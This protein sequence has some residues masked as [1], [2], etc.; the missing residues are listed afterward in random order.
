MKPQAGTQSTE[1]HQPGLVVIILN[2]YYVVEIQFEV[3][4]Y[5]IF[6]RGFISTFHKMGRVVGIQKIQDW[7]E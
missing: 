2:S 7:L 3:F 6:Y 5:E 1:P 4:K